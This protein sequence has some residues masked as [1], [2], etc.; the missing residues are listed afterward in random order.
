MFYDAVANSHGLAVDPFK[1][2]IARLGDG[3][4]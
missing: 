3:M 2:P 4:R 1:A